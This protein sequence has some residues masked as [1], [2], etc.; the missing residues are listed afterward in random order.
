MNS[1]LLATAVLSNSIVFN[2]S[3]QGD[4]YTISPQITV[5][6]ACQ[7]RVNIQTVRQGAGGNSSIQQ[8]KTLNIPANRPIEV[9]QLSLN[10]GKHDTVKVVVTL[11]D[12]QALHMSAQ[13]PTEERT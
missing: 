3:H 5:S 7:C 9:S 13:W 11:T 8:S 4:M 12:G 10:I 2:V 6:Q 1:L